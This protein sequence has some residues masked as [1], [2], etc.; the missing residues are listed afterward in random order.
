MKTIKS[1]TECIG[2]LDNSENQTIPVDKRTIVFAVRDTMM[3]DV[4][5]VSQCVCGHFSNN[6]SVP[7]LYIQR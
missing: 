2:R 3:R 1:A 7:I 5:I 6:K 4:K